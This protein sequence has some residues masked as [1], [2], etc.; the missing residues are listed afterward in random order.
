[1]KYR[2]LYHSTALFEVAKSLVASNAKYRARKPQLKS[3][4]HGIY[5]SIVAM[6]L[7]QLLNES[8]NADVSSKVFQYSIRAYGESYATEKLF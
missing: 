4:A 6:L 1:M 7:S 2:D 5:P 8:S 3:M